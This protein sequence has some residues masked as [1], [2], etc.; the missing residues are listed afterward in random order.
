MVLQN[1]G[2]YRADRDDSNRREAGSSTGPRE[3]SSESRIRVALDNDRIDSKYGFDR[4]RDVKERTGYLINMH[5]AEILDEDK[6]LV[7][8]MDYY[9]IEM[10][11]SRF[12]V[13]LTFQ[14]YFLILAR[15]ECE[16]E[17]IQFLSKRFAGTIHKITVIEK[18]DLDLL[19]H[20]SGLKQRYIK[21][22]FMSQNEMMKVRREILTAVNKNKE[23]EKKDQIYA[24][25]LTNALTSA[26]AI[27]HAK[28][29]TDHMENIL[30]IREHDV[31][32][33]VRVSTDVQ[34]FCGTWYTVK[35]RGTEVPIFTK[36]DDI[37][38]RPDPIVLAFD[39]E[40]TKLPLKFPDSQ[41]DQ[42][43]MISYMIDGQ[44][45]LIT[46]R[47][48]ISVDVED[49][50]YTPKPEFEGMFIVFN[51]ENELA[52]IQKFFDHIM[53][54]K[55]HIFVTYNGDFFDWPFV[56]ARAA[57]LG[58]D[59]KQ[60]IGF[61]KVAA[62][63]GTYACRPAMHM[64]CL[65]W[66]KRDSYLPVGSQGLKAVAKA[67]LR[68][69]P[70]ELDPEDMCRMAAEQPQVLS[71]YSVSDAVATY[72]LYMKYVHPFIFALCTIIPLEPDEVLRKGSGTL[73][74]SLLMVQAFHANIVFPNK[75][76]EELNK[77]TSDGHV[78]ET[79]TYVGGHVEALE[80]GVF[81]ADIKCKFK[82]VPSAVQEL[83]D[84]TEKTMKH[85][86]EVEEGIPLDMVTNFD[87]VCAE[88]KA[89]L[90]HMKDHPRRDE[91]PLI[92][93]LDV[94]AMYPNIILTN[95][96]Q[97]SAMVNTHVC[98][99]CDYNRPG[100][101]CQR[102]MEWMWR[103]DYLPATRSEYQRIQQQLE[104][105]KFPPLHPGGPTR[106][107]HALPKEDQAAYEKKRLADYCRVAYKKTKVTRTEVRTTTICQK[108]NSF[109]V[110]TVRAFRDRRY[111]YKALNKQAK[112]KVA[113]AVASGDAAEIKS[114]KSREVLYDSLQLAHKCI[115][116]SFYGY[117]MRR[118]LAVFQ[119]KAKSREV[120]YDSLQ[121]AHKCILN[122]F[123]GYVMRRGLAVFQ[124]K[125]KSREVLYDSLQLAHKCILNSFYGY[126][127]RRG[128]AVF[129][130][131][132]KSR[133]VLYDSLQLA[134]KCILNSFYGYVMRRGLAVF[135]AKAKSREVLYDSLQ[136]AHKC[137]LNSFYGYVMRRGLAVFQAKAK[138][139]EV[140]YDS[141]QLAHKCIL[142]SFYGYVM[143][144]GL[145][146]FQAKAKSR[147]VLY[148]SLQL[149]H[150]CILNSFY[151]YVM[152]RGLAVFQAKAKSREVLY[153]SL[154]LAHK[155]ILNSFYGYVMR[156]GARWHSME[157]AGIVCYTGANIIMKAREIIE[158]VGRP[159]ELDTDGIWCILPSSFPENVTVLTTHPKKKKINVSFP[160]A[161][162]N[163]MVKDHFTNDQYFE[164]VDPE[165]KKYEQRAENSI[166]FEVDGPY[167][168]MVLPASKEEGK[169]LKKRYAVFNFDGSLAELKG[170]EVKRRGELQLIKIF[171]SSV[172]EA[173][174]K[175]NDLKSCYSAVAKVADYWL[176]VLYSKGSNMPDSELFELIS[177]NRSMSKK[178]EDYGGQ[179]STSISTAKR[180]AEFLGDQMVKDAGL[181]CRFIISKKP[182]GAP[183]TERAIPL[184]IFQ[185]P[186]AVKRHHLRRWL[187]DNSISEDI[188]IRDVLDWN[189]YIERLS[190]TVQKIITIPAA[191][192]GDTSISEDID[193]RDVLD[194]NYYIERLSGTVQKIITIP[195]AMQGDTSI[196]E[197]IDIRDVLDWNYYIE[198]L[199]GTVQ[200]IITIP[201][202]MQGDTSISEDID[203]RDVLDWNY[204]IERLSGTVQKIITIPA[205]MQ[206]DTSISEDI[207]IR[208]VLDWNYYIERLSGTVQKIITIPAAMQG[209]TSISED[210]DI[211][212][213]LDWNYYIE[214]LSGTVQKIITI[215]AAMQGDTSISE[216]IDI[217]DVLD[218]NYYIERLSG[219]VQ[220]IITI[221]AA[222]QGL[223]NPVPRCQYPDWLHKK[224]LAKTDKFKTRKITDMFS[225]QP[226]ELRSCEDGEEPSTST[227][228]CMDT[229]V[230]I[231][232]LG[233]SSSDK[234]SG[235][236]RP[237]VHTVK[238]KRE[239]SPAKEAQSWR[240]ALGAPPPF[241]NT[242][243]NIE[244]LGKSSSDKES[245]TIRPIV[246]TVKRKREE[247]PA[248]EAQSW[249]EALGAPPP[250][251]NTKVNIEDLG[252]SSS[253]KE[254]G[255]IRPIVH[256][257]KRK[258]EES[259]AKE[260]QSWREALGAPP[261]FG[262]TKVN[263]EDLGK[264]SSDKESGTIRPI[265]HTVKRKR[266]ESPAKEAQSWREALGAPP[267]FGNTKVNIEDLGK[268]SSDKESGTIR[269]IVHTVKRKREESPAKEA[270]SWREALGAP[271]PFGNTKVNIEDLGKSSS[272]KESGTIRPIV[273]TVKRKREESPAKEAQSW[274]EAL[275]AP[276]PFGNTKAERVQWILFQKKKWL[277]QMEQRGLRNRNKRGK[278]TDKDVMPPPKTGPATT[279]GGFIRRA[280]R[281]LLNTPWQIIQVAETAEPG[282]FKVWALVGTELHQIKLSVPRIFYVNQRVCRAS[283]SGQ[284]WRKCSRVLPRAH[285]VLHLYQYTVP[286]N[287]YRE[288]QELRVCRA[289]DSGQYWRKCSRVL[290]RAHPVLHL[291]QYTVPEN[292]YREH[293]EELTSELC[294]P[295]IEGIYETQMS[296]EFR[297]LVQ[298]GCICTVDPA[299]ARKMIQFGS[300]NMESFSLNQLQFKSVALQ[301]YLQKQDGVAPVKHIYLYQHSALN[302]SRSM[303]ALVLPPVKRA[304][305]Y[306]LDSVRT[307]QVPN[308][309]TLY[310]AERTAKINLG[311]EESALPGA[312]LTWEVVVE[313][314][315]RAVSRHLQRALQRYKD[316]RCGPT[317]LAVQATLSPHLLLQLMPGLSDFP[318]VPI[319]VRDV[320]TLY[321]SLEWQRIGA[322]AIVRHYLGLDAV[323]QLTVEQCRYFHMPVGNM[324]ADPTLFG[325][326]LFYARH[327]VKHNFV[328]WCS[329][330]DRPDLGGR[331]IDDNRLVSEVEELSGCTHNA[332]AAYGTVCVELETDALAVC[333][334]L[335]AHSI[336]QVE[337]TSVATSFG[338]QHANIQDAMANADALA[339]CALLQAHSILQVEGTSVATSF[340]AQHA[341][342]QD[343]MANAGN[344]RNRR[345]GRVRAATST[346]HPAGG[347]HQRRHLLRSPT[348]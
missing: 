99:V 121:L 251:G 183:V 142:N 221:P 33:H 36:R 116:N 101:T 326:D 41:T 30:D 346:Q 236:I 298:L 155:C 58:L 313:T 127:M 55:P 245:G 134:H 230:D 211:R 239:E 153:D 88:I 240:E 150:K 320:E 118:G 46:N 168:A 165:Q 178:L 197:D 248:K 198:R 22:S 219:T 29:T 125:A 131:K 132:A 200:K 129:Q 124:A 40:T 53:D 190:G 37:I 249:R 115:L 337:G 295:E 250:F 347:G 120:L 194:W 214:R 68:Y 138:S 312:E 330:R 264:S 244:D 51:E 310:L 306:V 267:P 327:L 266:E 161:V 5:T 154:Q 195:A 67:K 322:R 148:D 7:A 167:L 325:A 286:E 227:D 140:L 12:K 189:Y 48:I 172:F 269:P 49:F 333:A 38:E 56:E 235:T 71:N 122:S 66:V 93:H 80:S 126:V 23:R 253:D 72:Y 105:E 95:R 151:G 79:E 157:M 43:M 86:I 256:T 238:R 117:V 204:Y 259:P 278:I 208:D 166:F 188:D 303:W 339:V 328:L 100:A 307:N 109:Y 74:E 35:S 237:I 193:I 173:F 329:N 247:S 163:A 179:K 182:D 78:L 87:E 305:I 232:D 123:Y 113:E 145:A 274:R 25:M 149:A 62:R 27:E 196:S 81:R 45:Y 301:P 50:E 158:Q 283:D 169:R 318:L 162:L 291:Y 20:L 73:C 268:S 141:L 146:V 186:A 6:R 275:G 297:V 181:A 199:S 119:A 209:D 319:H 246:H 279:L 94:G 348:R 207:D 315:A 344:T 281:T 225:V 258:R 14:P 338:A 17:V 343:A 89:K 77:L 345:A 187:K 39:I 277:W 3:E 70:V 98:A 147:E 293:Q 226:K 82:I 285:P 289:S 231:E 243:V 218:W 159:L 260:A 76:V 90:Q 75:Q 299:E 234:E 213:V 308:M 300:T 69:D 112:A 280:Q 205:A 34:I 19:N 60:E 284:Y 331:E 282:L 106:A 270:Q 265:V 290:P 252:K 15:K 336:L 114:A 317:L 261:P 42:I 276:P 321:S 110:D 156:R 103:G 143:R 304:Y 176:D 102:H 57:V 96:L 170:F 4:V 10:D 180:L 233:K 222:M 59:M 212:D 292:V 108:E 296:L 26:A 130:A 314:E 311:T 223:D 8:A 2:K 54:V 272:D 228:G 139:R 288:H 334:L 135:Q 294:A 61:S 31:P 164:L 32:Y 84:T 263:I 241:G 302:S 107:F 262:N 160:N 111:E 18:E 323:L 28:K 309:N 1:T 97:P 257:V 271:P 340:G 201:A 335:Q 255:T 210:I 65:C 137:I 52:L 83:M 24:E 177:E 185:S 152:R 144:R 175:G 91:N 332:S 342:I 206:G 174:L 21:L 202:A 128:L 316:E 104:T 216:D 192:Q 224:M 136:L 44:G 171:Q 13:S 254:S 203:I 242:K 64:D 184:A 273:H 217:R 191:M 324:P 85:A 63:D 16:Q 47:E 11:G 215:P 341:N 92:Y 220:K 229:E 287:V 9:F 133:E